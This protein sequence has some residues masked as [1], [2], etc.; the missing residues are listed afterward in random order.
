M[1]Q[2]AMVA[3]LF[4][5]REAQGYVPGHYSQIF[6]LGERLGCILNLG[7]SFDAIEAYL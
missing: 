2:R 7:D 3:A 1:P 4:A 5:F 6:A